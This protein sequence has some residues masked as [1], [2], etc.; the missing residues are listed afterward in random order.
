MSVLFVALLAAFAVMPVACAGQWLK[1]RSVM[2]LRIAGLGT[3]VA[4]L[5]FAWAFFAWV[6]MRRSMAEFAPSAGEWIE[7][8]AAL[9]EFAG[10]VAETGW[11]TLGSSLQP[12][13]F[14]LWLLWGIEA[15]I[16]LAAGWG[17]AACMVEGRGYCE[18]CDT[19]MENGV[20]LMVP[21]GDEG[22]G[23]VVLSK[24][25]TGILAVKP[26]S[27]PTARWLRLA[28]QDCPACQQAAVYQVDDVLFIETDKGAKK[29][30]ATPVLPLSWRR[31]A[32][33]A[34]FARIDGLLKAADAG[35]AAEPAAKA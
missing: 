1:V 5:Y 18:E 15:A 9:W 21:A 14:I 31:E 12:K 30:Q 19:W 11:Y 34:E 3:A 24:G 22:L 10:L 13:G 33:D 26:P 23:E 7:N 29:T 28:P 25:L 20:P 32:E 17:L 2:Q 35:R 16:L 27:E 4:A 8:P 6:F